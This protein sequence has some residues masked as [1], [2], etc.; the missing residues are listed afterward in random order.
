MKRNNR[1]HDRREMQISLGVE[2]ARTLPKF[3]VPNIFLALCMRRVMMGLFLLAGEH[4]LFLTWA[5]IALQLKGFPVLS[6]ATTK[7]LN[8][9]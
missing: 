5:P 9:P 7:L 1:N 2:C 3:Y 6:I 8:V 4:T